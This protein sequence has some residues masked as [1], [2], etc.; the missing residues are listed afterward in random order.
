MKVLIAEDD[1]ISREILVRVLEK[2]HY[3]IEIVANGSAALDALLKTEGPLIALLDW[4]MPGLDGPEVCRRLRRPVGPNLQR[5]GQ[6]PHRY[7][8]P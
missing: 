4:V 1:R 2:A 3:P 5:A 6:R 7:L 8:R